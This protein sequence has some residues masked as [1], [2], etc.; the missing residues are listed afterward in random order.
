[1]ITTAK[2]LDEQSERQYDE[3]FDKWFNEIESFS[4]RSE[5]FYDEVIASGSKQPDKIVPW[6]KAAFDAGKDASYQKD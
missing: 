3:C 4:F 1:M 2:E 6:L 5:R